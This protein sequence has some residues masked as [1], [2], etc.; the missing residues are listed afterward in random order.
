[1]IVKLIHKRLSSFFEKHSILAKTQYGFQASKSTS[2]AR[3]DV[4][5]TAYEHINNNEHTSL[6]PLDFKKAFD[7]VSHSILLYKLEHRGIR[8]IA[9]KLLKSFSS[10]RFQ[11]VSHHNSSSD[12]LINIFGVPQGSNLGLLL[13]Q[14]YVNEV[15]NSGVAKDVGTRNGIL[16][17]HPFSVQKIGEDQK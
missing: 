17:W 7:T 4:L 15:P 1:M 12:I 10:D 11:F 6:I 16:W 3:L 14:I 13:C 8:G 9:N 2:H 5:T